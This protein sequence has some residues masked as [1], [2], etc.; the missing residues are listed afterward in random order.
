MFTTGW[1][2]IRAHIDAEK[3]KIIDLGCGDG[4]TWKMGY[5]GHFDQKPPDLPRY[6]V[7]MVDYNV[8]ETDYPF[9]NADLC[10]FIK[11]HDEHYTVA[12]ES[13]VLEHVLCPTELISWGLNHA[14]R[15]IVV[16]PIGDAPYLVH[17]GDE[18]ALNNPWIK[19]IQFHYDS[20]CQHNAHIRQFMSKEDFYPLLPSDAFILEDEEIID[21]TGTVAHGFILIS[22]KNRESLRSMGVL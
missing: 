20:E 1:E 17:H 12:V 9:I 4:N 14:D 22:M 8:M 15:V 2:W 3:D 16:I 11:T 7:T 5:K 13:H 10:E 19:Y 21:S 18:A 6:N